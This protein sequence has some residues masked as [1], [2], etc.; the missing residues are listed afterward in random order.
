LLVIGFFNWLTAKCGVLTL[1]RYYYAYDFNS[2]GRLVIAQK[3]DCITTVSF[4]PVCDGYREKETELI[5]KTKSQLEEYLAG[6]RKVFNLPLAAEG[7]VFQ[8]KVW[9]ALLEIPYGCVQSYGEIARKIGNPNA[10]R[11]V[12]GACNK[13][14]VCIIVPCHRV[15]GANGSLTGYALGLDMKQKLLEIECS[16]FV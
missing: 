15:V 11:A 4:S 1:D 9:S 6:N 7:T 8:K 5:L 3:N 10:A 12:G 16:Q 13:N 14:P 2:I